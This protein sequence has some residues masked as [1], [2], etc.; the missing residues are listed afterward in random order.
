MAAFLKGIADAKWFQN[1]II[2]AILTAGVLVGIQTY[3]FSSPA[4]RG[5]MGRIDF[6]DQIILWI[7]VVEIAIK[8]GAEGTRPWRYFLD[9]WN[10]FDF[11]IVAVCFLPFNAEY[12]AVLRL[13]RLLRVLKLVRALPRLQVLVGALLKSIPSMAYVS[14]LLL[15]LFYVYACGA[16]FI[17]GE[18][19]PVHFGHLPIAMLSLF[20]VVTG[21]DW[22]DV[23]YIAMHG[24]ANYGYDAGMM[25]QM[26][27]GEEWLC[28]DH[29][30]GMP[31]FGAL[32]FVS[33][34]LI[35]AMVILNLFIGVI[36]TG[37]EEADSEVAREA[38]IAAEAA[39]GPSRAERIGQLLGD[40]EGI[41]KELSDL[42]ARGA[43]P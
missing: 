34:M 31:V 22:T 23:M 8:M 11:A 16:V 33:F 5:M 7:F 1:F 35:G 25:T 29:S 18:N 10:L 42:T 30:V 37:M 17:F 38:A 41:H 20:R 32:F 19:D 6:F 27:G 39:G 14:I 15:L 21:E 24:C 36:M 40:L 2:F 13:L 43:E 12:A 3:E 26:I 4:V 28:K 9:P